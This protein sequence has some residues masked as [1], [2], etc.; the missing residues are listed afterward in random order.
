MKQIKNYINEKLHVTSK[1]FYTCQPKTRKELQDIII[2]RIY[3]D[4]YD[5][6]L[7][8]IDVSKI[9]DMAYLFNSDYNKIFK[10][11]NGDISLWNVSNVKDMRGMFNRCYKFNGDI[12]KWDVS[13]VEKMLFMFNRCKN[14]NCNISQWD[15]SNVEDMMEMFFMC[16]CFRQNLDDWNVSNVKTMGNTFWHCPTKPKWYDIDEWE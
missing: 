9:E 8:D 5:C 13:N 10:E 14:F 4:G 7:N 1:S 6:N 16:E 15:V 11:F 2:Q 12:S 3:D